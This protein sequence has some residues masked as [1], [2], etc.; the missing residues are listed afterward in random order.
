[1]LTGIANKIK[2][3]VVYARKNK[4]LAEHPDF[5]QFIDVFCE[6]LLPQWCRKSMKDAEAINAMH[7]LVYLLSLKIH[8]VFHARV[9]HQIID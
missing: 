3:C 4:E 5:R 1:M 9:I 6:Q 2:A 8:Q 7:N